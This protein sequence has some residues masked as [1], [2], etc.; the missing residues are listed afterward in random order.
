MRH[1]TRS[2]TAPPLDI[3][4][5]TFAEVCARLGACR[6][7]ERELRTQYRRLMSAAPTAE[8]L[9]ATSLPA[10]AD[11]VDGDGLSKFAFR[12][13]D[14]LEFES[15]VVPMQHSGRHWK[16]VCVSTQIGCRYGCR[17]CQ[18]ATLGWQRD[19]SA[20]EIVAQVLYARREFGTAVRTVVFMGM[21]EPLDNL[22]NVLQAIR[23]VNDRS[24][25]ALQMARITL[26]TVGRV[27]GLRRLAKLGYKRLNLAV[28]LNAPNDALRRELMPFARESTLF[29]LRQALLDYP[30]R[31]N[32]YFMI[33]YVLV[34]GVNDAREHA[35]ELCE[36]LAPVRCLVNVIAHNP[37]P[38]SPWR[39]PTATEV[40]TFLDRLKAAGQP[41]RQR[42]TRGRD[43]LAACGQL[44]NRGR[45]ATTSHRS[46]SQTP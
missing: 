36:L 4:G 1:P 28:S 31:S 23:V 43:E 29:E 39:A 20:A 10:V 42:V 15:V 7:D 14:G 46:N 45:V 37:R 27:D 2:A 19:L 6:R 3:T 41:C 34:P 16:S 8:P 13:E 18:T 11:R 32:Q 17:F 12:A 30:L 21:G 33:E 25:M 35:R 44:G 9:L 26:S 38:G 5:L 24:G 40:Q 22:E